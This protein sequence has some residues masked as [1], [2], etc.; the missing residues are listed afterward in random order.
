MSEN[1]KIQCLSND[2]VRRLFNTKEDLPSEYREEIVENY[3][4]KL[5]TSGYSRD[6][7]RKILINGIKGYMRKMN[8][9]KLNGRK[10][11]HHSAEES[12][13]GRVKKKMIGKT[14]WYRSKKK[15]VAMK[16][17]DGSIGMKTNVKMNP[18]RDKMHG[19]EDE[20]S[21]RAVLILDQ[22]PHGELARRV[23]ELLHRLEPSMGF[24]LRVVERTGK[25]M[26][27]ILS[28]ASCSNGSRC[29]RT[30]CIT[31]NQECEDVPDC[32][33]TS[34]KE[35]TKLDLKQPE[36]TENKLLNSVSV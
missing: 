18:L 12:R 36:R 25:K 13:D 22:T 35:Q 19:R 8:R 23:K 15:E 10:R 34:V 17:N 5:V 7:T 14:L 26:K 3:G 28:P 9:R 16:S 2:M 20:V 32:T 31:C 24:R 6:Q 21:T 33:R 27:N 29:G 11:I 4:R 1:P 30:S